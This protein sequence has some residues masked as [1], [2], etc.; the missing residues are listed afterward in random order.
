[1]PFS[2]Y[3]MQTAEILYIYHVTVADK[4]D[5]ISIVLEW[6]EKEFQEAIRA[7]VGTTSPCTTDSSKIEFLKVF[8]GTDIITQHTA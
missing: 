2:F 5:W 3:L 6:E 4:W 8:T 7:E 1:M